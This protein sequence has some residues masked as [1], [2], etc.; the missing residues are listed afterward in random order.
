[1]A[2][3]RTS[4]NRLTDEDGLDWKKAE[5]GW[6]GNLWRKGGWYKN[7]KLHV[8]R[9]LMD[10]VEETLVKKFISTLQQGQIQYPVDD[11]WLNHLTKSQQKIFNQYV[12][13]YLS[14]R[15]YVKKSSVWRERHLKIA[16][17]AFSQSVW[18]V[19]HPPERTTT[20]SGKSDGGAALSSA[21][22][23]PYNTGSGGSDFWTSAPESKSG[24]SSDNLYFLGERSPPRALR[25]FSS[26]VKEATSAPPTAAVFAKQGQEYDS[27]PDGKSQVGYPRVGEQGQFKTPE[28]TP[29]SR[30]A[31]LAKQQEQRADLLKK[32]GKSKKKPPAPP[33]IGGKRKKYR[34]TKKRKSRKHKKTKKRKSR[35]TKRR[36]SRRKKSR[37]KKRTRR[38]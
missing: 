15:G 5:K 1:M 3:W 37:G 17:P 27:L 7:E 33:T 36:K 11:D 18:H 16:R 24:S 23:T 22:A 31:S 38:K 28:S 29:A 19:L 8:P 20:A 13:H 26:S 34:K 21:P 6:K 10:T 9:L 4:W 12:E 25:D 35:T 14:T 30:A 32:L 2:S